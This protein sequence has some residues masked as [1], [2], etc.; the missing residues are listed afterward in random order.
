MPCGFNNQG[1][2][3]YMDSALQ[4]LFNSSKIAQCLKENV[5][6][7]PLTEAGAKLVTLSEQQVTNT[8]SQIK[9]L[10]GQKHPLFAGFGQQDSHEFISNYL[11]EV[12]K[13]MC[14]GKH[15]Y[16]EVDY[17]TLTPEDAYKIFLSN[18]QK[19]ESSPI[20][21]VLQFT[22]INLMKCKSCEKSSFSFQAEQS[23]MLD[24]QFVENDDSVPEK[25]NKCRFFSWGPP[26]KKTDLTRC[27]QNYFE[28]HSINKQCEHC[29][30]VTEHTCSVKLYTI[31]KQLLV[32]LKRFSAERE[33]VE[34]QVQYYQTL[35]L[36]EFTYN[37][38]KANS[39][40]LEAVSL[41]SGG[42]WGGHYTAYV[43]KDGHFYNCDDSWVSETKFNYSDDRAYVLSYAMK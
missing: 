23:L 16:E 5:T 10:M 24:I 13:E 14:P 22:I 43:Q 11:E 27:L 31:P 2:T 39:L 17:S 34:H 15:T 35:D 41:H 19:F 18:Q 33:K 6:A 4:V 42:V 21:D 38:E 36:S 9:N 28:D 25:E 1:N 29:K 20:Q 30:S 7:G 12:H 8:P 32:I 37:P 3:C 40:E 26:Q